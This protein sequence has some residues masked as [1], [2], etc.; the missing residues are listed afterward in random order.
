[1][2]ISTHKTF[3]LM[4]LNDDRPR[5][6][7]LFY[8]NEYHHWKSIFGRWIYRYYLSWCDVLE[9]KTHFDYSVS[10]HA[11]SPLH[12][13]YNVQ[14]VDQLNPCWWTPP[15]IEDKMKRIL[16]AAEEK[17]GNHSTDVFNYKVISLNRCLLA[18][19]LLFLLFDQNILRFLNNTQNDIKSI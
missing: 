3:N 4:A 1:M 13:M 15:P 5:F 16:M 2:A 8:L 11:T 12:S 9:D 17:N 19:L 18:V 6:W 10:G 7:W 14:N